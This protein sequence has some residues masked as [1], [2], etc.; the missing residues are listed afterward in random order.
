MNPLPPEWL[1]W[2]AVAVGLALWWRLGSKLD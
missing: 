2:T 1:V